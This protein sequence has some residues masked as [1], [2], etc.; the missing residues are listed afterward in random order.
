MEILAR[1]KGNNVVL[2]SLFL[3]FFVI[4]ISVGVNL[5]EQMVKRS[6]LQESKD[7]QTKSQFGLLMMNALG[8][9][10]LVKLVIEFSSPKIWFG[11]KCFTNFDLGF[12]SIFFCKRRNEIL[13]WVLEVM[14]HEHFD[15]ISTF[16]S[17]HFF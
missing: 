13:V 2:R 12:G 1:T 17:F 7:Q 3:F 4:V 15:N 5:R 6:N 8:L 14:S 16:F 10:V 11:S 9:F